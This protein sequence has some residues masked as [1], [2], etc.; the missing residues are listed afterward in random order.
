MPIH[1]WKPVDANLFHHFHQ[2]WT[3]NISNAL[4]SGL[5][6]NE[7]SALVEQDAGG[8]EP[9]VLALQRKTRPNRP[10]ERTGGNVI[11][12]TPPRAQHIIR[13]QQQILARR[14]NR[15]SI[16]HSPGRGVCVIEIVS[17]GNKSSRSALQSFVTKTVDFLEQ[18]VHVLVIDLFPPTARDPQGIH[19]AI[20]EEIDEV[21]F[22]LPADKRLTLAA[23]V[24]PN[25]TAGITTTAYVQPVGVGDPLPDMPAYLDLDSYVPVPLE[26]TYQTTWAS[27]PEDM[28]A[29]VEAG[30]DEMN[31]Q[32]LPSV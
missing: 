27:C 14:A 16:R 29:V 30:E 28:R 23:Y 13:A 7:F 12:A 22:E 3:M 18:G 17:P 8:V 15:I 25:L 1:N 31:K 20:W 26:S 4:N 11:T 2:A 32:T 19:Q 5:L 21:P 24:A 6:P 9:D 10:L